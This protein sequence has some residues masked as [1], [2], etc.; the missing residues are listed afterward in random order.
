MIV[1]DYPIDNIA[2][3]PYGSDDYVKSSGSSVP[4]HLAYADFLPSCIHPGDA[5][6][7]P[8]FEDMKYGNFSF[9]LDHTGRQLKL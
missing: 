9:L 4:L 3:P 7:D 5:I 6:V 8:Q 2:P 1:F